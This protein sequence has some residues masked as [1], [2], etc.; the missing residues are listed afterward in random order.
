M[1]NKMN[2]S[3]VALRVNVITAE[4]SPMM[5]DSRNCMLLR[6]PVLA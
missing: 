4:R 3:G 2:R 5:L 1:G 6:P